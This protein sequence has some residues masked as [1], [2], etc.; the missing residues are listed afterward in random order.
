MLPSDIL[1]DNV[2]VFD[3]ELLYDHRHILIL[4]ICQHY[5]DS[6]LQHERTTYNTLEEKLRMHSNKITIF[7]KSNATKN[8]NCIRF[9]TSAVAA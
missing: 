6:R 9:E 1:E 5:I 7:K 8:N 3:F 4:L 2:D